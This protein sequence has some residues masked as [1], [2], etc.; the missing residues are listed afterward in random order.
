MHYFK[1]KTLFITINSALALLLLLVFACSRTN[2]QKPIKNVVNE[3]PEVS[4]E[5]EDTLYSIIGVGDIM[6]GT[7]YPSSA[8]LPPDDGENML[9]DV[10]DILQ[11]AD[12]TFGNLEG[13][14]L[15]SGGTPKKCKDEFSNC[16]S[17]RMP[18]HY[19]GYLKNAGFDVVSVANNHSGDMGDIGRRS[20]MKTLDEYKI[21]YAGYTICPTTIVVKDGVK[22]GFTAFAPNVGT[23][24]LND[25]DGASKIVSELKKKCDILIVSFHGGAEG[26][27]SQYVTGREEFFL[28]ED[29]GN[30]FEFA[31]AMIDAG[32][33]IIFGQGP[34]VTRALELYKNKLIAY[35]LG[36]FCTYGKFGLS[37]PLGLAPILKVYIDKN[38]DFMRGRIF[39]TKQIKR[40]G[41]VYDD[42]EKIISIMKNLT[43]HDF[44]DTSLDIDDDGKV[45]PTN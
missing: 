26:T 17:F 12:I 14:L 1:K 28:G 7:N 15:N 24:D 9:D 33:D 4:S 32:A 16:V 19:A 38:G 25:I 45:E 39:P 42:D 10:A 3:K 40:G 20:T 21:K 29:R 13:T 18:E 41:P 22:F 43:K 36:N 6:M 11:S 5:K 31:H 34:H 44:P 8:S 27:G 23:N 30:V 2:E 37:G 35:S